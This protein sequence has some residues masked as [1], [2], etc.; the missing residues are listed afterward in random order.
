MEDVM[1]SLLRTLSAAAMLAAASPGPAAAYP[2][3]CAI[4]LCLAGGWPAHPVC[5]H[6]RAVF[7][8]RAT[9]WPV[10]PPLQIWRCPMSGGAAAVAASASTGADIDISD[11]AFDPVRSIRVYDVRYRQRSTSEGQECH[12]SDRSR[13]GSYGPQGEFDWEEVSAG[14]V[15]SGPGASSF[16]RPPGCRTYRYRGVVV[17]WTDA[18]GNRSTEEVRY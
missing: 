13:L 15:P 18:E 17:G 3:D 6:A 16:D 5:Q 10:E 11:P 8:A 12:R 14:S 4:L 9:P 2:V 7:M 1:T